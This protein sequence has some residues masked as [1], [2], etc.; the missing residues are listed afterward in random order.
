M[1]ALK[2]KGLTLLI[3]HGPCCILSLAAGFIGISAFNHNPALELAFAFGGAIAG[4]YIGHKL[5][6]KKHTH[7][8]GWKSKAKRYGLALVFGLASWSVHQAVFHNKEDDHHTHSHTIATPQTEQ[9]SCD[10][11]LN[12]DTPFFGSQALKAQRDRLHQQIH[13]QH[14]LSK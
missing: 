5:F 10:H 11:D 2:T 1:S 6:D 8:P 3:E 4:E 13:Q 12:T 9:H 14:C 7:K